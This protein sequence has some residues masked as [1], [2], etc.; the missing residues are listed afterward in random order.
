M[1]DRPFWIPKNWTPENWIQASWAHRTW[2]VAAPFALLSML[3]AEVSTIA[4]PA[5]VFMPH[6]DRIR[7]ALPPQFTMR[8]PTKILLGGP[9]DQDFI[10]SLTVR[11]FSS[12]LPPGL[13][14]GLF[15]CGDGSQFCLIGTFAVASGNAAIAQREY[16]Q[17]RAAGNPIKLS[18]QVVGYLWE[19]SKKQPRS[20]FSSVMWQQNRLIYSLSFLEAERQ[21]MLYMAVSM[22]NSEPIA[23]L[24]A[25]SQPEKSVP[26]N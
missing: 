1:H 18:N 24:T 2:A 17:H 11:V 6:L 21:N 12:D 5:K 23:A 16:R 10:D 20:M 14:V 7:Q 25:G 8:L 15:S 22:A 3:L 13:T 19:G 4:A 26:K 9:A